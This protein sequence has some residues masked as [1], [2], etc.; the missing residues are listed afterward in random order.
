[1]RANAAERGQQDLP[2]FKTYA[3]IVASAKEDRFSSI[4]EK[5]YLA[6]FRKVFDYV[7]AHLDGKLSVD[8]IRLVRRSRGQPH[9]TVRVPLKGAPG[10]D[11]FTVERRVDMRK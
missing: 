5:H 8:R 11:N 6:R 10:D 9:P 4:E 3:S 7:D 2:G 1:M